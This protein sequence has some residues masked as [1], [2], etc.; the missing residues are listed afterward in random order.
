MTATPDPLPVD[1]ANLMW[2]LPVVFMLHD[3]EEIIMMQ[4]W[5][6]RGLPAIQQRFPRLA[7]LIAGSTGGLSQPAFALVVAEEFILISLLTWLA[8]TGSNLTLW[9][10]LLMGFFLHLL[11][12]IGQFIAARAYVPVIL[13]S[14]PAA[15]YCLY[16]AWQINQLYPI[17]WPKIWLWSAAMAAMI[18]INMAAAVR[19]AKGFDAWLQTHFSAAP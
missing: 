18:V 3:F 19:L 6:A 4:P 1:I 14:L 16:A 11:M 5:L 12:H 8:V 2:L 15:A 13:T 17:D 10:A 9:L 7:R